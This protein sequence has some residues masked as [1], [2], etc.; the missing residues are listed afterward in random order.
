MWKNDIMRIVAKEVGC[1]ANPEKKDFLKTHE[2]W[3]QSIPDLMSSVKKALAQ[4]LQPLHTL[5]RDEN[6]PHGPTTRCIAASIEDLS[7]TNF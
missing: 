4:N 7:M 3:K 6:D 5:I 2:Y 1:R